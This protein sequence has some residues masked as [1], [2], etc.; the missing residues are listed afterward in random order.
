[1]LRRI[2]VCEGKDFYF[3][4]VSITNPMSRFFEF[5]THDICELIFLKSGNV[6]GIIGDKIYDLKKNDLI[7]FRANVP[8]RLAFHGNAEYERYNILLDEQKLA[9]GIFARILM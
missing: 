8:H 2:S 6:S 3:S 1:M 4:H 9:G 5:H 7:I